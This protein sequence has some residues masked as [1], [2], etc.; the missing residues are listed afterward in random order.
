MDELL[1][2]T[3]K[4]LFTVGRGSGGYEVT[5][6]AHLGVPVTAV[7]SDAG[8]TWTALDHGHYGVKVHRQEAGGPGV[9]VSTPEYPPKPEDA[10]DVDPNSRDE[11]PWA[12]QMVW[13]LERGGDQL[14]AGTIPGGLFRSTDQG[15]SWELVRALW[16]EP[17]RREWFGGGYDHP[18]MHSISVDPRDA[19]TLLVGISCGGAWR[20]S[21]GGST[22]APSTGMRAA[23][24]P[25][26]R[27]DD[28]VIQ[29][30]H[31]VVRCGAEPDV[32]WVQHHNGIFRSTDG[33]VTFTEILEAGPSTFGFSV[34][35]HPHDPSTAWFVPAVADEERIPVDGRL[36]VTRTRDGGE[37]FDVLGRG[38]PDEHAYHLIYRHALDVDSTGERLAMASTTGSLWVSDD[39]GDSWSHVTSALPPVS[40][41]RWSA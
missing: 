10:A 22:W 8:T 34:A 6:A 17:S 18:G 40:C 31:R 37:S 36:V 23:F 19:G 12:T 2:G 11:V 15:A 29:D 33:G 26:E 21:D 13:C 39:S 5:G 20:T 41:V 24:M 14:W 32:V 35:V 38:L 7:L 27:A 1:V 25:P 28:P 4:G 9:E 16:D 30:P 3:R